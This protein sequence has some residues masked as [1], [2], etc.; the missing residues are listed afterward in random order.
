MSD[1]ERDEIE[2]ITYRCRDC[3]ELH[4]EDAPRNAPP[5][6]DACGM[7]KIP[8]DADP[9]PVPK[10]PPRKAKAPKRVSAAPPPPKTEPIGS[11]GMAAINTIMKMATELQ[12]LKARIDNWEELENYRAQTLLAR[13]DKIARDMVSTQQSQHYATIDEIKRLLTVPARLPRKPRLEPKP[14]S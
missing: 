13:V 9:L 12:Q 2:I 3:R 11:F 10:H 4:D 6:C 1:E 5:L 7:T 8:F 14:K